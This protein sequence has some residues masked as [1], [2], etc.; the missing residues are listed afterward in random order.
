MKRLLPLLLV[1]C[2]FQQSIVAQEV[3][4]TNKESV[5][6]DVNEIAPKK[7]EVEEVPVKKGSQ[8]KAQI[9]SKRYFKKRA[10]EKQEAIQVNALTNLSLATHT[11]ENEHLKDVK[12]KV[13]QVVATIYTKKEMKESVSFGEVESIPQFESCKDSGLSGIDCFNYEMKKHIEENFTY[14]E[15]A[16]VNE[17]EG[18]VWVSFIINING[19]VDNVKVTAPKYGESL[20]KEAVRIVSLLP[21]FVPGKQNGVV[22]NVEYTFPMSFTLAE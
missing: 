9:S 16:L 2:M 10:L 8:K 21:K 15:E 19:Y 12:E 5:V 18:N 1:M 7:C 6:V 17:I 22:T 4:T 14:P 11:V 3:C 20:K 13:Q